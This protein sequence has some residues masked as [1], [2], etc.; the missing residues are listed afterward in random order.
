M[1]TFAGAFI[2]GKC[3][4]SRIC[5]RRFCSQI[6]GAGG[7]GGESLLGVEGGRAVVGDGSG[8]GGRG[9]GCFPGVGRLPGVGEGTA[10]GHVLFLHHDTEE[11]I[12][13]AGGLSQGHGVPFR[14]NRSASGLPGTHSGGKSEVRDDHTA[15][16]R[17]RSE[18]EYGGAGHS[19]ESVQSENVPSEESH[20]PV[21]AEDAGHQRDEPGYH[22]PEHPSTTGSYSE[23]AGDGR[24]GTIGKGG[25]RQ[26]LLDVG[27]QANAS[28]FYR[29]RGRGRPVAHAEKAQDSSSS[30]VD[31]GK[32]RKA[33]KNFEGGAFEEERARKPPRFGFG[34][35][36]SAQQIGLHE[37]IQKMP[38][39]GSS[40]KNRVQKFLSSWEE[41]S[42]S[43][44]SMRGELGR[45]AIPVTLRK[46][47]THFER[48]LSKWED[49]PEAASRRNIE[50]P[51]PVAPV[52]LPKTQNRVERV[53][54]KWEGG[55]E[56][57][58]T[59]KSDLLHHVTP[60][61][62]PKAERP[63]NRLLS[64]WEDGA[65]AATGKQ[66]ERSHPVAPVTIPK[67]ENRIKRFLSKWE[68]GGETTQRKNKEIHPV[69]TA[70]LFKTDDRIERHIA[71][72]EEGDATMKDGPMGLV[73]QRLQS[74]S[75]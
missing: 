34:R 25:S 15:S 46:P 13:P 65:E 38:T 66:G 74:G 26:S 35:E 1:R 12:A 57:A 75:P 48:F 24:E 59:N 71:R 3:G 56:T 39:V 49:D 50:P 40:P 28:T 51:S 43:P 60:V 42:E 18:V 47:E 36:S 8:R 70:T 58:T 44:G 32:L 11:Q 64:K 22:W 61:S 52:I 37:S 17:Q 9:S 55:A 16:E 23:G 69:A 67:T 73:R 7:R 20:A 33:V 4:P 21:L 10:T 30:D 63:V 45:H 53:L 41:G 27:L 14:R 19:N 62:L 68:E 31:L 6:G 2:R 72:W 54:S 5:D 29:S